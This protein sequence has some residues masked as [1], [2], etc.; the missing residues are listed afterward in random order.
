MNVTAPES[1][2]EPFIWPA[3]GVSRVPYRLFSDPE[4]YALEQAQIFRGAVWHF[5]CL[6]IDIPHTGDFKTTTVGDTPI[7]AT[8]GKDGTVHAMVN[9]CAHKGALVCLKERGNAN[10]LSCIY[11]AWTYDLSGQLKGVAFRNG[12]KGKGGMPEDFDPA[13]HRMQPLRVTRL[14]GLVFGTFSDETPP[15]E[16]WLGDTMTA[17][18]K[19]NFDRPL[20]LLGVHSQLIHN[21]WKL[22][23]ENVRDSYHATLLHTFYTTFK[24]NRLDMDG[25]II[26]A[27]GTPWHHYSYAKRATLDEASEYHD[28]KVHSAQ[29]ESRLAAPQLLNAWDEFEDGITHSIQTVFPTLAF[30]FTLNSLA[31]RYFAPRGPHATELFWMYVGYEDDTP[32]QT[33]MRVMQGNL[34]GA[35]GLVSLEDGC[36]NE[37]VQRGTQGSA[38]QAA[39][40][41][42]GGREVESSEASRATEVAIRGFWTG[43]RQA[44][45]FSES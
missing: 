23:A 17:F 19:R 33:Q 30:H 3:A 26:L 4:I 24:V 42:M 6:E 45:G 15:I 27:D 10:T 32:E 1:L 8:R 22:Y 20:K 13:K 39:F 25:G 43:Y 12:I 36:I 35:A 38:D 9:R 5:L 21:N 11:H 7:V 40:M 28:A 18:M 41:E 29:F 14:F 2:S 37:F 31:V 44:M 34:T 16:D